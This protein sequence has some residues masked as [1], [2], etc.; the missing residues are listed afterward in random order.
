MFREKIDKA[1]K[2]V[3]K[4][5]KEYQEPPPIIK[6]DEDRL[7]REQTYMKRINTSNP[8]LAQIE[9]RKR[10]ANERRSR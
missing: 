6:P 5:V 8:R 4:K 9:K 3:T 10:R 7:K 1:V 2:Y